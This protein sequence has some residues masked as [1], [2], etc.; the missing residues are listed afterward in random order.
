MRRVLVALL[1]AVLV[2]VAPGPPGGCR[3]L[4]R[5]A[6]YVPSGGPAPRSRG[7]AAPVVDVDAAVSAA[8]GIG[9]P[10]MVKASA[11]GG[12]MGMAVAGDEAE[13]RAQFERIQGFAGRMFGDPAVLLEQY[14]PRV[15]HG[16]VPSVGRLPVAVPAADGSG[17]LYPFGHGL[18]LG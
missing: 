10:L 15:R 16:E 13:L 8:Q 5:R 14:F 7:T 4:P 6:T 12:G 18:D 9:Y 1:V 11:G 2:A 17:V 3:S